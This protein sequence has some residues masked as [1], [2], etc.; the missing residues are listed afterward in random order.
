[1]MPLVLSAL[2]KSG[3]A[4]LIL[5]SALCSTVAADERP[6]M[7]TEQ[8]KIADQ[9]IDETLSPYCTARMLHD[10]PSSQA[11][12]LRNEIRNRVVAGESRETITAYLFE[13]YGEA[14][15]RALPDGKG[16]GFIAWAAPFFFVLAGLLTAGLWLALR[17]R[18][19]ERPKEPTPIDPA[20]QARID[21][22]V[23]DERLR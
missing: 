7:T 18:S 11:V 14:T 4:L 22:M 23:E 13:R 10:C 16:K 3:L 5:L 9:I 6:A 1:M 21:S 15:V 2:R 19:T 20:V 17:A 8:T 12:A